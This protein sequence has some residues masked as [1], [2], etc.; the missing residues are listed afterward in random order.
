MKKVRFI[1][2]VS[3]L[4]ALAS[5]EKQLNIVPN[6]I[7]VEEQALSTVQSIDAAISYGYQLEHSNLGTNHIIWSEL[8]ADQLY[9]KATTYTILN[10]ANY[11][12]RDMAAV[13]EELSSPTS[14]VGVN[15]VRVKDI[16]NAI[17]MAAL[18]IRATTANVAA[19]DVTF[20]DNKDRILGE[21]YFLRG[22]GNFQLLR[23]FSR[24]WGATADNSQL[25]IV[26]NTEP[27][28]DRESQVKPRATVAEVYAF[29]LDDLLKAE[30]LL[31]VAYLPN[32]H[33]A[34]YNGRAYKDAATGYLAKVYFQKQDYVK[35]KESINKL[36]GATAGNLS[37]HPLNVDVTQLFL[38]RGPDNTD[39]E[40]IFQSTSALLVNGPSTV[41][42]NANTSLFQSS[43]TNGVASSSFLLKDAKFYA[44]DQR[45]IKLFAT[46]VGTGEKMPIKYAMSTIQ[47][48]INIPLIRSAEMILDRA[49]INAM[50]N[51]LPDAILDC[52]LIRVRALINPL[53][54]GILQGP[55]L[56]SIRQE[57]NRE[58]CF[59]GD[60]LWNLKRLRLPIPA[61]NRAA[62]ATLP[63]DG[64]ELVLKYFSAEASKNPLLVN[65]Y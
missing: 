1:L 60:R 13:A 42:W 10:Y 55:L 34:G 17:N 52:N 54:N 51:S 19:S 26:I 46:L 30:S 12:N 44:P 35:A 31:P 5:C 25:G 47:T 56:D 27:V 41:W 59:E 6:F 63:W 29:I 4:S 40:N 37:K 21:C 28:D 38:T 43:G 32:I 39:P 64:L 23:F 22:V 53:P 8:M 20:A 49:E 24:A 2:F 50:A 62:S 18:V 61:G 57:R 15:N 16:Y 11:Y 36:I 7:A 58:L 45:F 48:S 65:N 33:P 3:F 14:T 9:Y